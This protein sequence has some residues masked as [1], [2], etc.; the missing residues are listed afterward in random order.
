MTGQRRHTAFARAACRIA[1][2]SCPSGKNSSGSSSTQAAR[3]RQSA[4][5]SVATS[6]AAECREP[7]WMERV[8][9]VLPSGWWG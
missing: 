7:W 6:A 1:G 5:F 8:M 2:A 9:P 3:A 4:P